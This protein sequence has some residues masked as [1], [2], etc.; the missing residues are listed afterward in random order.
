MGKRAILSRASLVEATHSVGVAFILFTTR[1][2]VHVH[3]CSFCRSRFVVSAL[4]S[5]L[6]TSLHPIEERTTLRAILGTS[7]ESGVDS[8]WHEARHELRHHAS[9]FLQHRHK[10]HLVFGGHLH[11]GVALHS[12]GTATATILLSASHLTPAVVTDAPVSLS[13]HTVQSCIRATV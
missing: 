6:A 9:L 1:C 3:I 4:S 11:H 8:G 2:A 7:L 13:P 12:H 5:T 10:L